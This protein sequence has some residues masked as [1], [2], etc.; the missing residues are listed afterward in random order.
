MFKK[1][2]TFK[3]F[4]G[5]EVTKTLRFN[6]SEDEMLDLVREDSRF[7]PGYLYYV[8]EQQDYP[9]MMDILRKIIVLSYGELSN[10]GMTFRKT[11][12][13]ALD[14]LQSAAYSA[15][16]DSLLEEPE[17]FNAFLIGVFPS[18]FSKLIK[19]RLENSEST[20]LDVVK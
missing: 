4:L 3:N 6:L 19:E 16:R 1:D 2:L 5:N 11:D 12:E 8:M 14:F 20:Q 13:Q 18:K 10:D 15:F 9:M 17:Q 7:E